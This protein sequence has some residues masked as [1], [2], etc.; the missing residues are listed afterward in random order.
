[1]AAKRA[2][3]IEAIKVASD[4]VQRSTLQA[5]LTALN[6]QIKA[7]NVAE[8]AAAKRDAEVR[9][10]LGKAEATANLNRSRERE[11]RYEA[12]ERLPNGSMQTRG[13]FILATAKRLLRDI[14]RIKGD[15]K[16]PHTLEFEPQLAAFVEAQKVHVKRHRD[17]LANRSFERTDEDPLW[18]E[19]WES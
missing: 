1:M 19:T 18:R 9:R 10:K 5:D 3:L 7:A 6:A 17:E 13:E 11:Q 2:T 12:A 16:L 4:H 8:A 14:S 15:A